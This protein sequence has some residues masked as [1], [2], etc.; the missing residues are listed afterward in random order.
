MTVLKNPKHNFAEKIFIENDEDII[1]VIDKIKKAES[2]RILMI[3]PQHALL[4]SSIVNLKLLARKGA[5]MGKTVVLVTKNELAHLKAKETKVYAVDKPEE[6][7]ENLWEYAEE[8][9]LNLKNQREKRKEELLKQRQESRQSDGLGPETASYEEVEVKEPETV[10]VPTTKKMDLGDFVICAGGDISQTDYFD[11]PIKVQIVEHRKQPET[12]NNLIE[13]ELEAIDEV[14]ENIEQIEE[15]PEVEVPIRS[16][17]KIVNNAF[18]VEMPDEILK[19]ELDI[20]VVNQQIKPA[21]TNSIIGMD[22]SKYPQKTVSLVGGRNRRGGNSG[23]NTQMIQDL[24]TSKLGKLIALILGVA[25][26][27]GFLGQSMASASVTIT[28][29]TEELSISDKI[30]AD[31]SVLRVNA[32]KKTIPLRKITQKRSGSETAT[33]TVKSETGTKSKGVVDFLNK[34]DKEI[35]LNAGSRLTTL[36]GNK[37][38]LLDETV[39]IPKRISEVTPSTYENAPITAEKYGETYNVSEVDIKVDGYNTI[40]Q[41]SGRIYRPTVGGTTKVAII[42]SQEEVDALKE[43][44]AKELKQ[45]LKNDIN[46]LLSG[47]DV[48]LEGVEE[49]KELAFEVSPGIG[50]EADRF[51]IVKLEYSLSL[52]IVGQADLDGIADKLLNSEIENNNSTLK[53]I[54]GTS[55]ENIVLGEDGKIALDISKKGSVNAQINPLDISKLI[56]GKSIEEAE[57]I[58]SNN[59]LVASFE[60]ETKPFFIPKFLRKIPKSEDKITVTIK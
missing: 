45:M 56:K 28:P 24:V 39:K 4:T 51:D 44:M 49:F 26:L 2:R 36:N 53:S 22:I 12:T 17:V 30:F 7:N 20:P 5:D 25:I 38:F 40:S 37:V 15:T 6:V 54:D 23:I 9:S 29:T 11:V 21:R 58:L 32:D 60:L 41:L 10:H 16:N 1:F 14:E 48:L 8:Y 27:I 3:V 50:T 34:T 33:A 47:E 59:S 55:V 52:F 46:S 42:V 43:K 13:E 19:D 31:E 35:V 18:E 57:T